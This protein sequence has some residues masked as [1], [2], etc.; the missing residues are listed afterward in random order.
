LTRRLRELLEV[1]VTVESQEQIKERLIEG[2]FIVLKLHAQESAHSQEKKYDDTEGGE[3]ASHLFQHL[4]QHHNQ[5]SQVAS[6]FEHENGLEGSLDYEEGDDEAEVQLTFLRHA[7][8]EDTVDPE[9][10]SFW[11]LDEFGAAFT[12]DCVD[13]SFTLGAD[14][15]QGAVHHD[16]SVEQDLQ[17]V[18]LHIVL[19]A[20][21]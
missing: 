5:F 10:V 9:L 19:E 13:A 6:A 8:R 15:E 18:Q 4:G 1:L 20:E 11:D 17:G 12:N 14:E 7:Q 21:G 3:E 2:Y 16:G